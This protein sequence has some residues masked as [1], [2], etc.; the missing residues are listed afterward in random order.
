MAAAG[1]YERNQGGATMTAT[2]RRTV[3]CLTEEEKGQ[4]FLRECKQLGWRVILITT[5]EWEHG[6]WPRES[7]DEMFFMP[8]LKNGQNVLNGVSYLARTRVIDHVVPLNDTDVELAA[9]LRE[10]LRLPGMGSSQARYFRDKLAMRVRARETGIPA[11]EF[12]PVLNYDAIH[13]FMGRVPPPWLLKPRGEAG[14]EGIRRIHS[15]DEF[16]PAIE[17][18]GDR[19][20]Y[21]LL[22]QFIPGDICHVDSITVDGEIVFAEAHQYGRPLLDIVQGGGLFTTR[23]VQRDADDERALKELNRRVLNA[24]GMQRGV[25]HSE[26]IKAHDGRLLFL[27][28]SARVGGANIADL[29]EQATGLNLWRE[30][31]K[32][33]LGQPEAP[34]TLPPIQRRYGGLIISLARQEWPDLAGYNDPEV[35]WRIN[36]RHHAGLIVV[37]DEAE[38]VRQLLD[39]YSGRFYHDFF[40]TV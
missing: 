24:F 39:D 6:D 17:Q 18:L 2:H 34:Y 10:H 21:Y 36:K 14:S 20:S 35:V 38:R 31:A 23:T 9:D 29:V 13:E 27:E 8:D 7:I 4:E 3:L 22:E 26:F 12:V 40:A 5:S 32:I 1:G 33:E 30:W 15:A 16:W 37:S 28:T 11:P 19:Q 25:S